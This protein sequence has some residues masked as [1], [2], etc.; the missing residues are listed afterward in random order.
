MSRS[1]FIDNLLETNRDKRFTK[2]VTILTSIRR[3]HVPYKVA[4]AFVYEN[5]NCEKSE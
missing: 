1:L 3:F 5:I 4:A 2:P